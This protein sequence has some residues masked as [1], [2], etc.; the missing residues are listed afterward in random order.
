MAE[1]QLVTYFEHRVGEDADQLEQELEAH[2]EVDTV[3]AQGRRHDDG[4]IDVGEIRSVVNVA[5]RH[6]LPVDVRTRD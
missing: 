1:D 4:V 3:E 6:H 2:P 5:R